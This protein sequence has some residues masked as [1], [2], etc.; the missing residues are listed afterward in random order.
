MPICTALE[1]ISPPTTQETRNLPT[2]VCVF[3]IVVYEN[4]GKY[5]SRFLFQDNSVSATEKNNESKI[6]IFS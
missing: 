3:S 1:T 4:Q 2:C 5:I 6:N